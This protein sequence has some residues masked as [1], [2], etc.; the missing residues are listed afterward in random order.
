M[1]KCERE[2]CHHVHVLMNVTSLVLIGTTNEQQ[3]QILDVG[4]YNNIILGT[5]CAYMRLSCLLWKLFKGYVSDRNII[6]VNN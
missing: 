3:L 2:T 1:Y 5:G 6:L 4:I